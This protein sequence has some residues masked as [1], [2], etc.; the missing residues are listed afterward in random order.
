M[1][2]IDLQKQYRDHY[3]R[4]QKIEDDVKS[5]RISLEALTRDISKITTANTDCINPLSGG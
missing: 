3:L 2:L 4:Y 5:V 1:L